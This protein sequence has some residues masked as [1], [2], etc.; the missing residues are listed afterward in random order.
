MGVKKFMMAAWKKLP[1]PFFVRRWHTYLSNRRFPVG[2]DGVILN[3][4]GEVLVFHHTYRKTPWGMPSGWIGDEDPAAGL[5]REVRE[6]SGM[7][8]EIS[9]ILDARHEV[10]VY[11][12]HMLHI[13]LK[14]RYVGGGFR[15]SAE[16]DGYMFASPGEWPV[17][18]FR[19]QRDRIAKYIED[20]KI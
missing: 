5:I 16:V 15:K 4:A 18:M 12:V 6:E 2:V 20:G 11:G 14:G 8:I 3:D 10:N 9:G 19:D 13:T 17:G 7:D 1:I